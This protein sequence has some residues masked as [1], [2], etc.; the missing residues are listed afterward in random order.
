M[1]HPDPLMG[2]YPPYCPQC[3]HNTKILA[4]QCARVIS[5]CNK[6][7]LNITTERLCDTTFD[8]ALKA[9]IYDGEEVL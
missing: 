6:C 4:T 7:G 3:G 8:D 5:R 2:G 1:S 9:Y